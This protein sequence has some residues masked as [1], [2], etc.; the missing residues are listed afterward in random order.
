MQITQIRNATILLELGEHR[1][2]IDP[3]FS[4]AGVLPGFR[5]FRGER[6]KNP[7][8]ELPAG[9]EQLMETA[10]EVLITHE[11]PDHIDPPAI[12][13]IKARGLKVWCSSIDASNLRRKGLNAQNIVEDAGDL[14]VEVIPATHGHGMIGWLMGPV[15]GYFLSLPDEPTIYITGDTV[16][17]DRVKHAIA[18]LKPQVIVAPAGTANFGVGKD[19]MFSKRELIELVGLA[20]GKV[21][22]NH[23][24]SI[25]HCLMTRANLSQI[26]EKNG[27]SEKVLVPADG[28]K[29]HFSNDDRDSR[30]APAQPVDSKPGVQKWLTA[31]FSGT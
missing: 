20:P 5:L 18:R 14:S 21:V 22:F 15:A 25:D 24:E 6:R 17:T 23:L 16:L 10:T 28:E 19:L 11:H 1:I 29:L 13:W 30:V 9:S 4:S 7:L 3:M 26:M 31:K 8:T 2:L 12:D 27:Y